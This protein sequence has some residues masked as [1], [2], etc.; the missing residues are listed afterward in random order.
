MQIVSP[1]CLILIGFYIRVG[2]RLLYN[3]ASTFMR[4]IDVY[5]TLYKRRVPT[6]M[7]L[8]IFVFS[9]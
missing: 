6:W 3:V 1:V 4:C 2:Q 8:H 5:A 9:L 7:L